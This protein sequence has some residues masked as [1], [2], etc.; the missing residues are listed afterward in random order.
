VLGQDALNGTGDGDT[1]PD[2]QI[3]GPTLVR[4]RAER[5]GNGSGRQYTVTVTCSDGT[6]SASRSVD[7]NVP[8]SQKK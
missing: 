6:N 2:F 4:L 8:K 1:S 7:V 5:A 3:V